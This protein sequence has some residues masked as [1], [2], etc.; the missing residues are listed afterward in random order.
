MEFQLGKTYSGYQF[1]DILKRSKNGVD[2]RVRNTLAERVEVLRA[3]PRSAQEDPEQSERF[4]REMRVHAS[5][6]HPNI[7]VLFN[8]FEIEH[9]LVMTTEL[10][11]GVT[12]AEKLKLGPL[13]WRD[14]VGLFRQVLAAIGC[15]HQRRIVHRDI[16]PEHIIVTPE[17]LAKLTGFSLAKGVTSPKLTQMGFVIGNLKYISP[18]QIR[19]KELDSR[20]DLYSLGVVLY[21][22]LCGR[23][24]FDAESQFELMSA[25]VSQPAAPLESI[26]PAVPAP[27]GALVLKAIAKDPADRFQDVHEFD[28]ALAGCAG[29]PMHSAPTAMPVA[30]P[31]AAESASAAVAPAPEP[32]VHATGTVAAL[33]LPAVVEPDPPVPEIVLAAAEVVERAVELVASVPPAAALMAEFGP[34]GVEPAMPESEPVAPAALEEVA[35]SAPEV[36]APVAESA[37]PEQEALAPVQPAIAAELEA[38]QSVPEPVIAAAEAL[39]PAQDAV[40]AET[41]FSSRDP[42]GRQQCDPEDRGYCEVEPTL[43]APEPVVALAVIYPTALAIPE[44]APVLEPAA[45]LAAAPLPDPAIAAMQPVLAVAE[46]SAPAVESLAVSEPEAPAVHVAAASEAPVPEAVAPAFEAAPAYEPAAAAPESAAPPVEPV[47]APPESALP[48]AT[49]ETTWPPS[50]TPWPPDRTLWIPETS[51]PDLPAAAAAAPP[52]VFPADQ[53]V[54]GLPSLPVLT[55]QPAAF[56]ET[57]VRPAQRE[58]RM[59]EPA[60]RPPFVFMPQVPDFLI[61]GNRPTTSQLILGGAAG[62]CLGVLLVTLWLFVR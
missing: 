48:P 38:V 44:A 1:L 60:A 3:L 35:A 7:V 61:E 29:L 54:V 25:H 5:L 58:T 11:E 17:G 21:E 27:L 43:F 40:A 62:A 34:A 20:S 50:S 4:L 37:A 42:L 47:S 12:L 55:L 22:T 15:A 57:P 24:P 41:G 39:A 36:L 9:H 16:S 56:F 33:P 59:L 31:A 6:N 26:N 30:A 53:P 14:A 10:V 32:V 13:S 19:G 45:A 2:Y 8:A 52:P 23:P 18:E 46:V 49:P 51:W 28:E